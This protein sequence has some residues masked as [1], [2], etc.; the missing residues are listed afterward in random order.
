MTKRQSLPFFFSLLLK[1]V[2]LAYAQTDD[3]YCG[4]SWDDAALQCLHP[5]PSGADSDCSTYETAGGAVA[6]VA[7]GD[8][9]EESAIIYGCYFFTGCKV[10]IDNG[11]ITPPTLSPAPSIGG[12]GGGVAT[13]PLEEAGSS[14]GGDDDVVQNWLSSSP[15]IIISS[16]ELV[17]LELIFSLMNIMSTL[18]IGIAIDTY[19]TTMFNYITDILT[20]VDEKGG[21]ARRRGVRV[22]MTN[23]TNV[24]LGESFDFVDVYITVDVL[25]NPYNID[26]TM[27]EDKETWVVN[28]ISDNLLMT[29][30]VTSTT[31]GNDTA[32][33]TAKTLVTYLKDA[34]LVPTVTT[35]TVRKGGKLEQPTSQESNVVTITGGIL[36]SSTVVVVSLTPST[37][38]TTT[39]TNATTNDTVSVGGINGT[40]PSPTVIA[41]AVAIPA[42]VQ[43]TSFGGITS[44]TLPT[45]LPSLSQ[46]PSLSHAPSTINLTTTT[47]ATAAKVKEN[48]GNT[49]T[50]GIVIG[51]TM[52]LLL[53]CL[54]SGGCWLYRTKK[55][56]RE[57]GEGRGEK[58]FLPVTLSPFRANAN[59]KHSLSTRESSIG[60]IIIVQKE[61]G[62]VEEEDESCQSNETQEPMGKT[63][64]PSKKKML[65]PQSPPQPLPPSRWR[66]S[67]MQSHRTTSDPTLSATRQSN[68]LKSSFTSGRRLSSSDTLDYPID[69]DDLRLSMKGNSNNKTREV[70]EARKSSLKKIVDKNEEANKRGIERSQRAKM[71]SVEREVPSS[72][73]N[74]LSKSDS[75]IPFYNPGELKS[76]PTT[77]KKKSSRGITKTAPYREKSDPTLMT[78]R[79]QLRSSLKQSSRKRCST[80]PSYPSNDN[81]CALRSSMKRSDNHK[82]KETRDIDKNH[83]NYAKN[84]SPEALK[85]SLLLRSSMKHEDAAVKRGGGVVRSQSAKLKWIDNEVVF[86]PEIIDKNR[87]NPPT[88][89]RSNKEIDNAR[90]LR[91][92][93]H[94]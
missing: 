2:L 77:A 60:S 10:K 55:N 94:F 44:A 17:R 70:R 58:S 24:R 19:N 35:I 87:N 67:V 22:N 83:H 88:R 56:K 20:S 90:A 49:T 7:P 30:P 80:D 34:G 69:L 36:N 64:T 73:Y 61:L 51:V 18:E 71:S 74:H 46:V 3:F 43:P 81:L 65:H 29:P 32:T 66:R 8:A 40:T 52:S 31:A 48:N 16:Y 39:S 68:E 93:T 47:T 25:F 1:V 72:R 75:K 92:S 13:T 76:S 82:E 23:I 63:N 89:R 84:S 42:L 33:A 79:N 37:Y 9:T 26:V 54:V 38:P 11:L 57:G 4:Y 27:I 53:L 85:S 5:C 15:T 59:R 91:R 78:N 45:T 21:E 41:A 6:A 14:S 86:D 62:K 28:E 50:T 12:G